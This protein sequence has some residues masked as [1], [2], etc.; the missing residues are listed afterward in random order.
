MRPAIQ[1][2]KVEK[3]FLILA[4]HEDT[5]STPQSERP[6]NATVEEARAALVQSLGEVSESGKNIADVDGI[7]LPSEILQSG[8]VPPQESA[9][10]LLERSAISDESRQSIRDGIDSC[11]DEGAKAALEAMFEIM[12]GESI[13]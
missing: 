9:A 5:L 12:T 13:E 8:G 11:S 1:E 4:D 2:A 6:G 3:A 10:T 7:P